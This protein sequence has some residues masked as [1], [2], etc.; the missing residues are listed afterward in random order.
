[1]DAVSAP[2]SL[3]APRSAADVRQ[4]YVNQLAPALEAF[5][6]HACVLDRNLRILAVNGAWRTFA[7]RHGLGGDTFG[8]GLNYTAYFHKISVRG[9]ALEAG[10]RAL[11]AGAPGPFEHSDVLLTSGAETWIELRAVQVRPAT[12]P[13]I[14]VTHHDVSAQRRSQAA[15]LVTT[16]RL[17]HAE[18]KERRRIARDMH[19][20]TAQHLTGAKMILERGGQTL[21]AVRA[22][23]GQ[24]T[25]LISEALTEIRTL[26][27]LLHPPELD[28]LGLAAAIRQYVT[29][30]AART[31]IA[32]T[33]D[34][35]RDFPR[36][37]DD[38]EL[39]LYRV[40]QEALANVHSHSGS[41]RANI[42]LRRD[43]DAVKLAIRDHGSGLP[44]DVEAKAG[45]GLEG[46]KL[47]LAHL[48]GGLS[49]TNAGPGVCVEAWLPLAPRDPA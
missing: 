41:Q 49:V 8:V 26:A 25:G 32:M 2:R 43:G 27:Y 14:I 28:H 47:R 16:A 39:A 10:L 38:T 29:G 19:D 1:M 48:A 17:L 12:R 35:P 13:Y 37:P 7:S 33:L 22:A 40:V 23:A 46:M 11:V 30:Y 20:S 5:T 9:A 18:D 42:N 31:G 15:L 45:V 4:L 34:V 36:L 24:A 44:A 21:E 6:A 3:A